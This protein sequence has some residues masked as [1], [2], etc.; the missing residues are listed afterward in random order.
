MQC[1]KAYSILLSSNICTAFLMLSMF[2]LITGGRP[3]LTDE[4]LSVIREHPRYHRSI[5]SGLTL[6]WIILFSF[7]HYKQHLKSASNEKQLYITASIK[8]K[9]NSNGNNVDRNRDRDREKH[10]GINIE[11]V[12]WDST[13]NFKNSYFHDIEE[14]I[15]KLDFFLNNIN[16]K[17]NYLKIF[18]NIF[19]CLK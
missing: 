19:I 13:I 1:N 16:K 15:K 7:L 8:S 9:K 6:V 5:L 3:L 10:T 18:I 12:P 4:L 17:L 11:A 2:L 14:V